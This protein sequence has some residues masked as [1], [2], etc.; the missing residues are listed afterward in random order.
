LLLRAI[1]GVMQC[2]IP[3]PTIQLTRPHALSLETLR[4]RM[5]AVEERL[6]TKYG[7]QTSWTDDRTLRVTGPGVD[8]TLVI[9]DASVDVNIE[10][11]MMLGAFKG[12]LE[13][14]LTRQLERIVSEDP[15]TERLS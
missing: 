14:G 3:M 9:G 5:G 2:R 13:E 8:G 10:L 15:A 4:E 12:K 7:A 1:P 11:G 6:N